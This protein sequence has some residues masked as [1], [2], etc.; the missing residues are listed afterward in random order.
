MGVFPVGSIV[1][2]NLHRV[3]Q[4]AEFHPFLDGVLHLFPPCRQFRH[5]PAVDHPD[6][7]RTQPQSG[8]GGVHGHISSAHHGHSFAQDRRG[9]G[10]IQVGLHQ[11][12]SGEKFVCRIDPLQF[13]AGNA[14][15]FGQTGTGTQKHRF[16][17]LFKQVVHR[18]RPPNDCI[19]LYFYA[20][21]FQLGHFSVHNGFGQTEFGNA[22]GEHSSG[23]MKRLKNMNGVAFSGQIAGTTQ[24]GGAGANHRYPV[25]VG[26]RVFGS[27]GVLGIVKIRH[28]AF[29][30][31][32]GH[33]L[34]LQS[35]HTF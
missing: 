16:K 8:S 2:E 22:V 13:F 11:I 28:I 20:Q 12:V 29:Q 4:E 27:F 14:H 34:P 17:A 26:L 3:L 18:E 9:V 6:A 32:D 23:Q 24:P 30:P 15:K 7:F 31:A 10:R 19:G 5:A 35:P 33:R 1:A 21:L 25:T